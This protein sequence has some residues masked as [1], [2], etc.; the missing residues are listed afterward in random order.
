[1]IFGIQDTKK[2]FWEGFGGGGV[3]VRVRGS[4]RVRVRVKK[5]F[6]HFCC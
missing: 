3:R 5:F 1:M 2:D 6:P 4:G